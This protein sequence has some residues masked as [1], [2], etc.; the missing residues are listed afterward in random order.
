[1][2]KIIAICFGALVALVLSSCNYHQ[3]RGG[4]PAFH[5]LAVSPILNQTMLPQVEPLL[6]AE[7]REQLL[8]AG[9]RIVNKEK[10]DAVLQVTLVEF[11]RELGAVQ[12]GDSGLA[13]SYSLKLRAEVTLTKADGTVLLNR[14][15]VEVRREPMVDEGVQTAEYQTMP[16]ITRDLAQ[17]ICRRILD[18]W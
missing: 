17:R 9:T 1:M 13:R 16:V 2:N 8:R 3:G 15:P 12:E 10:A 4:Q 14:A 7:L 5:T 18:T 11:D 6:D